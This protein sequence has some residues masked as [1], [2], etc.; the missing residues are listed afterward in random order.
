[1]TL[2]RCEWPGSDEL[3]TTYH[4]VE[5]GVPL[6][7]DQKLFEFMILDAMQ[8]GLSWRTVLY[9]RAEFERAMHGFDLVKISKYREKDVERLMGNAGIIRNRQK[10]EASVTNARA[11]LEVQKE[12]GSLDAYLWQFVSGKPLNN[13]RKRSSTPT[14]TSKEAEVMSK[15]LKARGFKFVGPTICYAFMQAAGFVN[16]H[17]INCF[18]YAELTA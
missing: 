15:D 18:R 1:M 6:H 3:M 9:K 2:Q 10:I 12:F 16:D 7:D 4:D 13:K 17:S 8:A 5:W 14:V 11:V